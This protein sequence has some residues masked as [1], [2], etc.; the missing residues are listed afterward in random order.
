MVPLHVQERA[1]GEELAR[2]LLVDN[3]ERVEFSVD[4]VLDQALVVLLEMARA[5]EQL[6]RED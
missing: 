4:L 2:W 1:L 5:Q 6:G 3:A